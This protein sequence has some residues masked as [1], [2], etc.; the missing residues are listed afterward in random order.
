VAEA[1]FSTIKVEYVHRH[2]VRTGNEAGLKIAT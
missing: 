1:T 2:Q